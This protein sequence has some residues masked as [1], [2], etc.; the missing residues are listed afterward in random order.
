M[1][2]NR[3]R[4]PS[5]RL[6]FTLGIVALLAAAC[7]SRTPSSPPRA[8]AI[9]APASL[10][11]PSPT[12]TT[13]A[14]PDGHY[15][16]TVQQVADI[17]RQLDRES[18]L[19]DVEKETIV[20]SVL[21]IRGATTIQTMIDVR[22]GRQFLAV[23]AIDGVSPPSDPWALKPVDDHTIVLDSNCCGLQVFDVEWTGRQFRLRAMSPAS[24]PVEQFVRGVTF[25]TGSF[26]AGG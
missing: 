25:E 23:M 13:A 11:A 26:T 6:A 20:N 14:I 15:V 17:R 8:A 22:A 12:T 21:G 19:T 1:E 24:S 9:S 2:R 16:G 10:T 7:G 3:A 4:P 18:A 5:Q